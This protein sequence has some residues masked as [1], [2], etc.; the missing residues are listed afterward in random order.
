MKELFYYTTNNG[1]GL[2]QVLALQIGDSYAGFTVS[3]KEGHHLYRVAY[4]TTEEWSET[5]LLSFFEKYDLAKQDFY[6]VQVAWNF[7]AA[8]FVPARYFQLENSTGILSGLYGNIAGSSVIAESVAEWQL[9][10][11][12]AAPANVLEVVKRIFPAAKYRHLRT[13]LLKKLTSNAAGALEVSFQTDSFTV[14]ATKGSK[15]LLAETYTYSSPEDVLYYLLKICKQF[16]LLQQDVALQLSG[17]VD[18][19]SAL[20]R[21]LYQYFIHIEFNVAAWGETMYPAH[22]FTSFN[23]LAQCAL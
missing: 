20:Y 8:T 10:T 17:L 7:S 22:F 14:I 16:S 9:Q 3:D 6:D 18:K 4:C 2:P 23:H 1:A 21:E 13:L 12:Y 15:L 5:D 11:T 19:Q